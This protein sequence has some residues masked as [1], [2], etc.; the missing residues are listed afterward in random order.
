M[1]AVEA[2]SLVDRTN[3]WEKIGIKIR[4]ERMCE[5]TYYVKVTCDIG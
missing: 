1:L 2:W 3:F 4:I 5:K